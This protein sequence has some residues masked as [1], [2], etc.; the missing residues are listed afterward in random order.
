LLLVDFAS[1]TNPELMPDAAIAAAREGRKL[2]FKTR[3][4]SAGQSSL[5]LGEHDS[6]ARL[7]K[8]EPGPHWT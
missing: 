7:A 8:L 5:P 1:T 2:C 3:L 6:P 4:S